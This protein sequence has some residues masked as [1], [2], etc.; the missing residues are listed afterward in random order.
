MTALRSSTSVGPFSKGGSERNVR[1]VEGNARRHLPRHLDAVQGGGAVCEAIEDHDAGLSSAEGGGKP[2]ANTTAPVSDRPPA[3]TQTP[4][5]FRR[6]PSSCRRYADDD[7]NPFRS[8]TPRDFSSLRA[9]VPPHGKLPIRA[10]DVAH[11]VDQLLTTR[12][13]PADSEQCAHAGLHRAQP[14]SIAS[15]RSR[16]A[17]IP[18]RLDPPIHNSLR[19]A[20]RNSR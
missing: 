3:P 13:G 11:A 4:A 19:Y 14:L 10:L 7:R 20:Q 5:S 1:V 17:V 2:F 18:K 6:N 8:A 15:S 16:S 9:G 12:R